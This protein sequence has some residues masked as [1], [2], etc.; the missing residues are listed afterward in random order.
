MHSTWH[1]TSPQSMVAV[2]FSTVLSQHCP[3]LTPR[4]CVRPQAVLWLTRLFRVNGAPSLQIFLSF[5]LIQPYLSLLI[6]IDHSLF[7]PG[8]N[9]IQ[10][11]SHLFAWLSVSFP[12]DSICVL[13]VPSVP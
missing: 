4:C 3:R 13:T 2:V 5:P 12:Q 11:V 7:S 9:L 1:T 6:L 10:P 8:V